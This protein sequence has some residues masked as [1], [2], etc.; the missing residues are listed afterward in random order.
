MEFK[1]GKF[2][3]KN[4]EE[5]LLKRPDFAQWSISRYPDA[6]YVKEFRRLIEQFNAKPFTARCRGCKRRATRASAYWGNPS[7]M[8]WCDRCHPDGGRSGKIRM[9]ERFEDALEHVDRTADSNRQAK[10]LVVRALA[11]GKGLPLRVARKQAVAFFL[12]APLRL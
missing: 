11:K 9:I 1:S 8:F 10:K 4:T 5:V 12:K 2:A 3:G 6:P 7:L